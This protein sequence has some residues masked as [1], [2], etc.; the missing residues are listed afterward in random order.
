LQGAADLVISGAEQVDD[1]AK[2]GDVAGDGKTL[3]MISK[4]GIAVKAGAPKPDVRTSEKLR[5]ALLAAKTVGYSQGTSGQ[6]FLIVLQKLGI[7]DAV[8]SKAVVV[9][10]RPVGAAIATGEAEIG[11]QQVAEL[12]PV[13][14]VDQFADCQASCRST[15]PFPPAFRPRRKTR[16]PRPCAGELPGLR[17]GAE[18]AQAQR[19]G[20]ALIRERSGRFNAIGKIGAISFGLF[21]APEDV[22]GQAHKFPR[23]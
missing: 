8:K 3:L 16:Q 17:A 2:S 20:P 18:R 15:F 5:A 9:Q 10:G 19:N 12:R 14:G 6:H 23:P 4:V 7:T 11:V 21:A 22:H 1:L 13:P